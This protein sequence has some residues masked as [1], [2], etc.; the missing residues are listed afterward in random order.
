LLRLRI[1]EGLSS[2]KIA[3]RLGKKAGAVRVTLHRLFRHLYSDY[4]QMTAGK[5]HG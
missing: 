4:E 3:A 1:T 2:E 5:R